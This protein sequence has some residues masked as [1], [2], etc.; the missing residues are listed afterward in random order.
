MIR[1]EIVIAGRRVWTRCM[2]REPRRCLKCQSLTARHLTAKC[3]APNTCSTCSKEHKR[4][5]CTKYDNDKFWCVN[6]KE[7]GHTS[8]DHLCPHF[9]E[10]SRQLE[11]TDPEHT[12]RFFPSQEPWTWE[13]VPPKSGPYLARW[14]NPRG[15][16][17]QEMG[18]VCDQGP[19]DHPSTYMIEH[20][21][22][23]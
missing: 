13:Q 8:W 15:M 14:Q 5:E 3:E 17:T 11:I 23:S 16:P 12:Y 19:T 6:C 20:N 18:T 21:N 9:L 1:E 2:R 10:A 22:R 7:L 4:A